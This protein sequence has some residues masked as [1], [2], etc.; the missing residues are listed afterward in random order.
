MAHELWHVLVLG[1]TLLGAAGAVILA[2]APVVF[3]SPPPGL[4][5]GRPV[6]LALIVVAVGVALAEWFV[7]H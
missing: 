1:S 2:L 5:A 4:V 6:V 3:E 7:V